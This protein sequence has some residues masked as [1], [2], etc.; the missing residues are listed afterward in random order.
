M[1]RGLAPAL[2]FLL[3]DTIGANKPDVVLT[4][5]PTTPERARRRGF[6]QAEVLAREL[7]HR[8][9]HRV[10]RT[11]RRLPG[12]HQTGRNRSERSQG[13]RFVSVGAV[14]EAIVVVDDVVTTGS[15]M[16]AAAKVLLGA[17]AVT[18]LGLAVAATPDRLMQ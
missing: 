18:V 1:A 13:V 3:D 11:L 8:S 14:P 10:Q 9:G 16:A 4:W 17:G 15:T 2:A 5:A 6:D 7:A 12:E